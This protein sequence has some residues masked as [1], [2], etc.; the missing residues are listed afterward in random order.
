MRVVPAL[1]VLEDGEARFGLRPERIEASSRTPGGST[2][3]RSPRSRAA[4]PRRIPTPSSGDRRRSDAPA[5]S[6]APH[7][8]G[9]PRPLGASCTCASAG[10]RCCPANPPRTSPAFGCTPPPTSVGVSPASLRRRRAVER[11]EP[12]ARRSRAP[13]ALAGQL[14]GARQKACLL[15]ATLPRNGL[16]IATMRPKPC[17]RCGAAKAARYH[18]SP[19]KTCGRG[20]AGHTP[21]RDGLNGTSEVRCGGRMR[22]ART[23]TV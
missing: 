18:W 9:R 7:R 17:E 10:A 6:P 16:P 23:V 4:T 11:P 1:D 22:E 14:V 20:G 15:P 13:R 5:A 2:A 8:R 19:L 21:T 12:R 3:S